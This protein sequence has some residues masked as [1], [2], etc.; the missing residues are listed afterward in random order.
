MCQIRRYVH[1]GQA[2]G[3]VFH[4]FAVAVEQDR[5]DEFGEFRGAFGEVRDRRPNVQRR[6]AV[7][8]QPAG[9]ALDELAGVEHYPGLRPRLDRVIQGFDA[10]PQG[11]HGEDLTRGHVGA[12]DVG[13]GGPRLLAKPE[14]EGRAVPV[15][16]AVR[17]MGGRDLSVQPV[18]VDLL[19]REMERYFPTAMRDGC[20]E[21]IHE[22]RMNR[23]IT[24]TH[25]T[26][27][28]VNRNGPS[29]VFRLGEE[30]GAAAPDI[31]RAYMA[32]REIFSMRTL[33]DGV[34]ALDNT[35]EA[36]AQTR[37]ML[38]ARKLVERATRWL[39]RY[40]RAPLNVG[41]TISHFS[42]GAA[43][44]S[45]LIPSI[46]LDGDRE[47]VENAAKR[48]TDVNVPPDLAHRAANLGPMFSAL[49]I[50]DVANTTGESLEM[51]AAV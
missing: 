13:R 26:N 51:T 48:L 24:A 33:W 39:L 4:R 29:F 36:R 42:E 31:A 38:D 23:Q 32:A 19:S 11:A 25:I 5:R 43:E 22:H 47:A 2:L 50:T 28:L 40:R 46:L 34:E 27:S 17:D 14:H 3:R 37:I 44:L 41:A 1:V 49:D 18:I 16:Q 21:Q 45:K 6:A 20:S 35:V 12:R 9:R 10:V 15:H 8:Q 7:A 30:T